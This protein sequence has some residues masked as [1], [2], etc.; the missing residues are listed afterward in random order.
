VRS[1]HRFSRLDGLA[2]AA[3]R[4]LDTLLLWLPDELVNLQR[5]PRW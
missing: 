5:E 3:N 2:E 1:V 4:R